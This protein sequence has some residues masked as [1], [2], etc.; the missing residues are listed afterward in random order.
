MQNPRIDPL[1]ETHFMTRMLTLATLTALAA[2]VLALTPTIGLAQQ[3]PGF[4]PAQ[5]QEMMKKFQDPAA[6]QKLQQQAEA[7]SRCMEGIDEKQLRGL[8]ARAEAA[9]E[10]IDKLCAAGKK[11]E[12]L[13]Q[14]LKL[15]R[16][17]QNDATVK[18]IRACS[19]ELGDM[20]KDMPW[21]NMTGL[22]DIESDTPPTRNDI[23]S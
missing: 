15:S 17:L 21:A 8:Q 5:M 11:D 1:Q 9:G 18:K 23:C 20:M 12:A 10:E 19:A 2:I 3:P 16:E 14:G 6:M 22:E 13:R 7:A 4:D